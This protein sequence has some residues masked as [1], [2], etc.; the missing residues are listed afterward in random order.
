MKNALTYAL[1]EMQDHVVTVKLPGEDTKN[2]LALIEIGV[3]VSMLDILEATYGDEFNE[4]QR[5]LAKE[6]FGKEKKSMAFGVFFE[7]KKMVFAFCRDFVDY[8]PKKQELFIQKKL[9]DV[10]KAAINDLKGPKK[11]GKK[12]IDLP[13]AVELPSFKPSEMNRPPSHSRPG[14]GVMRYAVFSCPDEETES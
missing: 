7:G 5:T 1:E 6:I 4:D 9:V 8:D 13:E 10:M 3:K 12:K 11:A 2:K 14:S